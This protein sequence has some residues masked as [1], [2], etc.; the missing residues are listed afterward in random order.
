MEYIDVKNPVFAT[1][2]QSLITCDVKFTA[3]PAYLPFAASAGDPEPHGRQLYAELIAGKWGQVGAYA[4]PAT[5]PPTPAQQYAAAIARGLVVTSTSTPALNGTYGVSPNDQSDIAAEAQFVGLYQEFTNGQQTFAWA[6]ATGVLHTFPSTA[7]FMAFAKAA[8]QYVS[9]CKQ[10]WVAASAA[11]PGQASA[12]PS[13][14]V[15][16]A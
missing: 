8:A 2:D 16:L 6:D 13:N 1:R 14:A 7:A 15:C 9:A 10:A 3:W 11:S 5:T 4:A 12:F